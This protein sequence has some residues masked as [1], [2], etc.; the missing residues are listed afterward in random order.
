MA[1]ILICADTIRSPEM[2][3]EVPAEIMDPFLYAE[4]DGHR[5]AV[6]SHLEVQTI[7][8]AAPDIEVI[9]PEQ[10]GWDELVE[11]YPD[12]EEAEQELIVRA[13]RRM[14]ISEAVAPATFPLELADRLRASGLE[15]TPDHRTFE[16]RRRSKTE[17]E[18]AGI[19]RAQRAAETAMEA[20]AQLLR[21]AEPADGVLHADGER[22]RRASGVTKPAPAAIGTMGAAGFEPLTSERLK[23]AIYEA[24]SSH[25]VTCEEPIVAHGPQGAIGH[26]RGSGPIPASEPVVIDLWPQDTASA[27]FADMTR[28]FVVGE[29]PEEIRQWHSLCERA[30][31][32]AKD[33]IRP[34]ANGREP[35]EAVCEL[36][37]EH[38][39][40]TQLSKEAGSTLEEGFN[41]SLGHGVGLQVHE[42]PA[43]GRTRGYELVPGDVLAVEPGLYRPDVG[44]M[45]LEDLVLV[46]DVGAETLTRY[47]YD[48]EP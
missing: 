24:L 19:G 26:E 10:L 17:A 8:D 2:R 9:R 39:F 23:E 30:L 13:C 27:C 31:A 22:A 43:L 18:L 47:P 46:T 16:Q 15:L 36:F 12:W 42:A 29:V 45:R 1:S 7:N 28:T 21:S 11:R 44:G 3:H 40:P 6:V 25:P 32:R 41:H 35:F 14:G 37:G 5:Y 20:A 33:A 48:L 4:V 34:G 38:G